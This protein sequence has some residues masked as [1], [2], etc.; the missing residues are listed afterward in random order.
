VTYLKSFG[1]SVCYH[2][3]PELPVPTALT[4]YLPL[5]MAQQYSVLADPTLANSN[6]FDLSLSRGSLFTLLLITTC[7]TR[8]AHPSFL[9]E[10]LS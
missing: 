10:I 4:R 1:I 2:T 5:G 9:V 6:W 7:D 8:Y 3:V